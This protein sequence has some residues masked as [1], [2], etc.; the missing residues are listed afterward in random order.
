MFGCWETLFAIK[1]AVEQSGYKSKRTIK[2]LLK[3]LKDSLDSTKVSLIPR[4]VRFSV[5]KHI[6][7]M[8]SSL[9]PKLK[10]VN[11]ML[12]IGHR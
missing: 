1:E 12:F 2:H 3:P 11:L 6:N 9:F 7:A 4:V 8:D 5:E 10:T